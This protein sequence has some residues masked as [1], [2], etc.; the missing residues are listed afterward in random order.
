MHICVRDIDGEIMFALEKKRLLQKKVF[1][2]RTTPRMCEK[3]RNSQSKSSCI[4]GLR[5]SIPNASSAVCVRSAYVDALWMMDRR[6]DW[7]MKVMKEKNLA[8]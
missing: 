4:R 6:K 5:I 7:G 8:T 2:R 3:E 1:V